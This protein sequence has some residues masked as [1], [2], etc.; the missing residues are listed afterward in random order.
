[1]IGY[2]KKVGFVGICVFEEDKY[3]NEMYFSLFFSFQV[4]ETYMCLKKVRFFRC[5]TFCYTLL[6]T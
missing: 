3:L 5:H 4:E 1:V 6:N 2:K